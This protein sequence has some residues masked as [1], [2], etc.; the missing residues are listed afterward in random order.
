M[1]FLLSFNTSTNDITL[2]FLSTDTFEM[3][4]VW[5][6][7]VGSG[8]YG[9]P[10]TVTLSVTSDSIDFTSNNNSVTFSP[11]ETSGYIYALDDYAVNPG[12]AGGNPGPG[13]VTEYEAGNQFFIPTGQIIRSVKVVTG[14]NTPIGTFIGCYLRN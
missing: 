6:P 8:N 2:N 12:N 11:F 7:P 14:S 10:Y 1:E 9:I 5:S 4:N 3:L 13:G